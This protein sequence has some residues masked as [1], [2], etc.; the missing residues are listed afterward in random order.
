MTELG[1]AIIMGCGIMGVSLIIAGY[2][3]PEPVVVHVHSTPELGR[4]LL[5]GRIDR[6]GRLAVVDGT[7]ILLPNVEEPLTRCRLV[8]E[9]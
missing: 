2:N 4:V 1:M 7:R 8:V 6:T 3:Q 5:R 9:V